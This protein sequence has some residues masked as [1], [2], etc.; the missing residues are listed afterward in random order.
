MCR[1]R[2][3]VAYDVVIVVINIPCGL[4]DNRA[5]ALQRAIVNDVNRKNNRDGAL[6]SGAALIMYMTYTF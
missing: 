3:Y 5:A 2:P 1:F 6:R 4:E